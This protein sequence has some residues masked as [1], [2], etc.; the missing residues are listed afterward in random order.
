MSKWRG[1][2][3]RICFLHF[4]LILAWILRNCCINFTCFLRDFYR[5]RT[6]YICAWF[7]HLR[8]IFARM[9]RDFCAIFTKNAVI[10]EE[11]MSKPI[12]GTILAKIMRKPSKILRC[13]SV[14]RIMQN[15]RKNHA[16]SCQKHAKITQN[17]RETHVHQK[18][19]KIANRNSSLVKSLRK[20]H[21]S[22]YISVY[23]KKKILSPS[24]RP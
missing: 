6:I 8:L 1:I 20:S 4:R 3:G 22:H 19:I 21:G 16:E 24:S 17:S 7:V 13:D 2:R 15:S 23:G 5:R 14:Y 18:N 12:L 10:T 11:D 9:L